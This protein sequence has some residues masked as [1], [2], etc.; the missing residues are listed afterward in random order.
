MDYAAL[1]RKRDQI[2]SERDCLQREQDDVVRRAELA[3]DA[4][5]HYRSFDKGM[6]AHDEHLIQL[7]KECMYWHRE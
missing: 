2:A 5:D 6:L 4:Y 1:E 3:H 7:S